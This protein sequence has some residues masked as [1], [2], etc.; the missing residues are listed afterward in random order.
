MGYCKIHRMSISWTC[1]ACDESWSYVSRQHL[2]DHFNL[3]AKLGLDEPIPSGLDVEQQAAFLHGRS[4]RRSYLKSASKDVSI[5]KFTKQADID[6]LLSDD[7]A[8]A[9]KPT[10]SE[11]ERHH[12][13]KTLRFA[14]RYGMS[15]Q[16]QDRLARVGTNRPSPRTVK[17]VFGEPALNSVIQSACAQKGASMEQKIVPQ[18]GNLIP[19]VAPLV[20][21][22]Y[23]IV[24]SEEF[25][26]SPERQLARKYLD[27]SELK[28]YIESLMSQMKP[29]LVEAKVCE[30]FPEFELAV[31][32]T[33]GAS[34]ASI[35]V[36]TLFDDLATQNRLRDLVKVASVTQK[37]LGSLPDGAALIVRHKVEGE[38]KADSVKVAAMT[39]ADW[40][41]YNT[42]KKAQE[43][44]K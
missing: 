23:K 10:E 15:G 17:T 28:D 12:A 26:E 32:K 36:E 44:G 3:G 16:M 20:D 35:N 19:V 18:K 11:R 42:Q 39:K 5:G 41:A 24:P 22:F 7:P 27:L 9:P 40:E 6:R 1:P 13:E 34:S 43:Q 25:G 38:K 29:E 30:L 14:E 31:K 8:Q 4:V 2:L 37:A 33:E 21:N